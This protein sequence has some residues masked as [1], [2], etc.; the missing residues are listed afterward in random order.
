VRALVNTDTNQAR[1]RETFWKIRH[2]IGWLAKYVGAS[3]AVPELDDESTTP[4]PSSGSIQ[5]RVPA[6]GEEERRT[7][8]EA[9]AFVMGRLAAVVG[10]RGIATASFSLSR[11]FGRHMGKAVHAA[12]CSGVLTGLLA[13]AGRYDEAGRAAL[14]SARIMALSQMDP[15]R[16]INTSA[17]DLAYL[18]SKLSVDRQ[19]ESEHW[20]LAQG[21]MR[22]TLIHM[23]VFRPSA[24]AANAALDSLTNAL[25]VNAGDLLDNPL[26]RQMVDDI[27]LAWKPGLSREDVW[28]RIRSCGEGDGSGHRKTLLYLVSTTALDVSVDEVAS[29]HAVT[30]AYEY[31]HRSFGI[32][33]EGELATLILQRWTVEASE[34]AFR[35][36][37]P[38]LFRDELGCLQ[39]SPASLADAARAV[40]A[41]ESATG[42]SYAVSTRNALMRLAQP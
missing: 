19:L 42:A 35:L 28:E 22:S 8:P 16:A 40:L 20:R 38:K 27:R 18:W 23:L 4:E 31:E 11:D 21:V 3:N 41:A 13:S 25:E 26:Y 34:R 33:V 15:E 37:S 29:V 10:A 36:S 1:S 17:L 39:S 2:L 6:A 7:D 30:L 14:E 5:R 9:L 32:G 24:E 12:M